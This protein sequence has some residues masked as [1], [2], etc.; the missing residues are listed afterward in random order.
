MC[1]SHRSLAGNWTSTSASTFLVSSLRDNRVIERSE[2]GTI[3]YV[4]LG[5]P[6]TDKR[7]TNLL[8]NDVIKQWRLLMGTPCSRP[9]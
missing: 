1:K 5:G 2:T 7:M 3:Q 9:R 8:K 6:F 4:P